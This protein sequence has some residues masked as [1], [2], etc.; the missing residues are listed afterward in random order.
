MIIKLR[1]FLIF[2]SKGDID[3]FFLLAQ[4]EGFL[5]FIGLSHKSI[6]EMPEDGRKLV[7]AIKLAKHHIIHPKEAPSE[8]PLVLADKILI[9]QKRKEAL[10]EEERLLEGELSR[11]LVFGDFSREDIELIQKE[12]K[13]VI[14]FFC[15]KNDLA[16]Q[17]TLPFDLIFIGHEYDLDYFVTI[18]KEKVQ[19]PKLAEILIERTAKEIRDRLLALREEFAQIDVDIRAY[20][21]GLAILQDGLSTYLNDYHL[22]LAKHAASS[23]LGDA[24]FA[25]EAWVP[26]NRVA[27][28]VKIVED[29]SV[30]YEE[31]AV[32]ASDF[33]PTCIENRGI[34]QAGE[35]LI[36]I[37]DTPSAQDKDPSA[38]V[39]FFFSLFFAIII[40]DAGYG[41][42]F[43]IITL[44]LKWKLSP[45]A[46]ESMKRFANLSLI[47]ALTTIAWGCATASFFGIEIG[48]NNP[49]RKSSFIH[50]LA[51]KK[52]D[53]H[54]ARQDDVYQSYVKAFPAV[55]NAKDGHDF[56]VKT[57]YLKE[58][59]TKYKAL[60]DFY[61]NALLEISLI[62]G[63]LHLST[64]I[65]RSTFRNPAAL[66]WIFFMIGGY[67][68][69]P[70]YLDI[71]TI[72]NFLHII[73]KG[74]ISEMVGLFCLGFGPFLVLII[75]LIE[76]KRWMALHELTNGVQ[77]F[78]DVLS[79]LR[80]Y[81]LALAGIVMA[82]TMNDTL[83]IELGFI[84][85]LLVIG[86]GHAM[87]ISMS[88]MS[89]TI[90]GL[91]LNF[92][93]WYRYSFEGGGRL[94]NPLRLYK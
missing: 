90:H 16:E 75:S 27:D 82:E 64:S 72:A 5:E 68:Y 28:L 76:G 62:V 43:L 41:L 85:T 83:G 30:T 1:K 36:H 45:E 49:V 20:C 48:P 73:P 74:A 58:G 61:L 94:F 69:F 46:G 31:V 25:I 12:G 57:E 17:L 4:Q 56:L 22:N 42:I 33:M 7:S 53:Y 51:Q 24:I 54:I 9:L 80:L 19:H 66:G 34:T 86:I 77:V 63:I 71:T 26:V 89:A 11:V 35:D 59:K 29:L 13:R 47:L 37:Y 39:L 32:T 52:A 55:A 92:L 10:A 38:W 23:P 87:N 79:Y 14:Q 91:R 3:Q 78:S 81:A 18:N 50:Y 67:I 60:E 2:G 8:E 21:N 84:G 93:E 6:L 15:A 40:S 65:L 44:I 88:V 70:F